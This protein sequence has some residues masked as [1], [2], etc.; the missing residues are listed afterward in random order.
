[1]KWEQ[2]QERRGMFDYKRAVNARK[3]ERKDRVR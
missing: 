3:K 2:E 1:M